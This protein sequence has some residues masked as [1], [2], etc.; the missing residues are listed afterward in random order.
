MSESP[1]VTTRLFAAVG[2]A[3]V[4]S[5]AAIIAGVPINLPSHQHT[6]VQPSSSGDNAWI[7]VATAMVMAL[8]P[9]LAFLYGTLNGSNISELVRNVT[10]VG[11]LITFL[12]I[13]F[14]FSLAYGKDAKD[15]GIIGYP[16]TYYFFHDTW[17][18]N[19]AANGAG[20]I[21][22]SIFAVYELGFALVTAGLVTISL[23]GRVNLNSFLIFMFAWH[24]IVYTPV[25]H[26]VWSPQGAIYSNWARDF[27][28]ALV[29][30]VLSSST[31]IAL[32]LV[33]GKDEIPKAGA[34][35]NPEK[36]LYLTFVV[37]FLWFGFNAGKA[38]EA[39]S[40]AAQSVVNTIAATMSSI[41]I[42]F[43]YNLVLEKPVTPVSL[44]NAILIGLVAITPASGF[45]TVGGAMCIA[46]FT[47]LFT[48][49]VAQFFIGEGFN[50]HES[51]STLTIHGV[52]GSVG[53]LW[54]A[55]IS[56]HMVNPA[57]YNG[58][59]AGRGIPLGYQIAALMAVW[60]ASFIS[61]FV[62]AWITNL[63]TPLKNTQDF[64]EYK[65]PIEQDNNEVSKDGN[66]ELTQV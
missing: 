11:S 51:F 30:H 24:L 42:S 32:H 46:V 10:I 37:W 15:N 48:A 40:V 43:F 8:T 7:I 29:V 65:A 3:V 62:L 64:N 23:A 5:F 63:I 47:Y 2:A 18:F 17:N 19:A 39:N 49:V 57:G 14:S 34:V 25:A 16:G 4:I 35:A 61:C 53:F 66:V 26:I 50:A 21:A 13:L 33:L 6:N 55:I 9:A 20:N 27:S 58:L 38:H 31:S 12:W 56:Y 44:S 54:T 60:S 28:G 1:S 36:A 45:V 41:L 59:T 22:N 52:A